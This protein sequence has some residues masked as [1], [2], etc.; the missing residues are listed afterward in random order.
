MSWLTGVW[1]YA[2]CQEVVRRGKRDDLFR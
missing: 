1:L 2:Y